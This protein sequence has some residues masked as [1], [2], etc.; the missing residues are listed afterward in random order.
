[1]AIPVYPIGFADIEVPVPVVTISPREV[2]SNA[3]ART[4]F[5]YLMYDFSPPDAMIA[6]AHT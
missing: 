1:M 5:S 2:S 4:S 3:P 6:R